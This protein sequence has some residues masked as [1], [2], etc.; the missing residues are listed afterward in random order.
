M[1]AIVNRLDLRDADGDLAFH[2]HHFGAGHV[3]FIWFERH[4][5]EGLRLHRHLALDQYSRHRRKPLRMSRKLG[6][7]CH[8]WQETAHP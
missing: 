3:A 8:A 7:R 4:L 1:V 5:G 2:R 6:V